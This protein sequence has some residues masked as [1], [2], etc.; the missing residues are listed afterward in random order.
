MPTQLA[1]EYAF[2]REQLAEVVHH[3]RAVAAVLRRLGRAVRRA[4][5]R[6]AAHDAAAEHGDRAVHEHVPRRARRRGAAGV[7]D[8]GHRAAD[9]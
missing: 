1:A 4:R 2:A 3:A 9:G 6:I 8:A 5:W 7:L